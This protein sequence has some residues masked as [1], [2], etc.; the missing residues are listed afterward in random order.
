MENLLIFPNE[1]KYLTV[2]LHA[3]NLTRHQGQT[4]QRKS[5]L[6]ICFLGIARLQPRFPHSCVCERFIIVPGSVYT[7]FLQ[8][9]RQT[10]RGNM[11]VETGTE[12]PIFFFWEYLLRNFGILSLQWTLRRLK[13]KARKD[14]VSRNCLKLYQQHRSWDGGGGVGVSNSIF[15]ASSFLGKDDKRAFSLYLT[16]RSSQIHRPSSGQPPQQQQQQQQ[17]QLGE[18]CSGRDPDRLTATATTAAAGRVTAPPPPQAADK[19]GSV[20]GCAK[21]Q[22]QRPLE[23]SANSWFSS[24]TQRVIGVTLNKNNKQGLLEYQGKFPAICYFGNS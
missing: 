21:V 23:S 15:S 7:Y 16:G 19:S 18:K 11:N 17:Q 20:R 6:C 10:D 5:H 13:P 3:L 1:N 14:A 8:Q 2:W 12:T 22:W 4:L 9:N 24:S